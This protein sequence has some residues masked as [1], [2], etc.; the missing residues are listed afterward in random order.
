VGSA[1]AFTGSISLDVTAGQATDGTGVLNILGHNYDL[2]LITTSTPGN[3]TT[4]GPSA[5]VGF[6]G[7]DGTDLFALDQAYPIDGNG[8]LFDVGTLTAQWGQYPL[9]A[10]WSNGDGSYSSMFTGVVDGTEYW[11]ATTDHGTS[12]AVSNTG[13]VPEPNTWLMVLGGLLGL[14]AAMAFRPRSRQ[15]SA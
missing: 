12:V 2:V 1:G 13:V 14:G 7:N 5:P 15:I 10:I 4:G 8:L 6:R 11:A 3:E 9:F